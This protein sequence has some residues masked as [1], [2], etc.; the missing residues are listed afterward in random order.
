MVFYNSVGNIKIII[1]YFLTFHFKTMKQKIPF[2]IVLLCAT[3]IAYSQ[4]SDST[5][6]YNI[7]TVVITSNRLPNYLRQNPGAVA[8]VGLKE[9]SIMPRSAAAEEALRLVPGV[10][11]DNQHDGERIHLSIRGQG[12]LT[13]RGLRGIGVM[14]DGIPVNDPSGFAPDLYDI[15]WATVNKIEVLRRSFIRWKCRCRH[16]KHFN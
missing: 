6:V 1:Q 8:L 4:Q 16:A 13:E 3:S 5:K 2:L 10:R 7:N 15:D 9:L 12:I 11:I 14:I